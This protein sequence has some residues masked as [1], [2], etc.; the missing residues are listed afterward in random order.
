ML[1]VNYCAA[2]VCCCSCCCY[3]YYD[4]C[5]FNRWYVH[6]IYWA[7]SLV[8]DVLQLVI[9]LRSGERARCARKKYTRTFVLISRRERASF[10]FQ[11]NRFHFKV[12]H[13]LVVFFLLSFWFYFSIPVVL[14]NWL[15]FLVVYRLF[16][17][18]WKTTVCVHTRDYMP[19]NTGQNIKNNIEFVKLFKEVKRHK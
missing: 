2:L 9:H 15:W 8:L 11:E 16:W 19:S 14:W 5:S 13:A 6:S 1:N 18:I 4:C 7:R 17:C 10:G 12:E 3:Y